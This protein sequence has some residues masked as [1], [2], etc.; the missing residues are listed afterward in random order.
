MQKIIEQYITNNAIYSIDILCIKNY[1][2]DNIFC[3]FLFMINK[4]DKN[5]IIVKF[6]KLYSIT[7]F[8]NSFK[9][10]L[11][12]NQQLTNEEFYDLIMKQIFETK[13]LSSSVVIRYINNSHRF[14]FNVEEIN[15]IYSKDKKKISKT[16]KLKIER[17]ENDKLRLIQLL[18]NIL[19]LDE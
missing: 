15:D 12:Q 1:E 8:P 19:K 3:K 2:I 5:Q 13:A 6:D 4:N 9:T 14:E 17:Y 16:D 18:N 11:N 7:D 10:G